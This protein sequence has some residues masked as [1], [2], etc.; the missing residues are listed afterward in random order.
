MEEVVYKYE[1]KWNGLFLII[2]VVL[3][4]YISHELYYMWW[5]GSTKDQ[6]DGIKRLI[7]EKMK[8]ITVTFAIAKVADCLRTFDFTNTI[9]CFDWNL[10]K[11]S[12]I[13][14]SVSDF[15]RATLREKCPNTE[16]FLV[17][18]FLYSDWIR[19]F[20]EYIS[21][22]SPNTGKYGPEVTPYFDTFHAVQSP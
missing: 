1:F 2:K 22:F 3:S 17:H 6:Q 20:M 13:L 7:Q 10:E 4:N 8:H 21:V 15:G 11:Q 12:C 16:L 9:K 5:Q 18:I 19:R 14:N